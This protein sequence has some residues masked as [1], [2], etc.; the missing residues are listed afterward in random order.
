M[1][2]DCVIVDH[3][4]INGELRSHHIRSQDG[5]RVTTDQLEEIDPDCFIENTYDIG[6]LR[7]YN[8]D[9][10][11]TEVLRSRIKNIDVSSEDIYVQIDH[12]GIPV[13]AGYY[14]CIFP[15]GWRIV[16]ANVYDPYHEK[17][18]VAEKRSYRSVS[19]IWDPDSKHAAIQF[20]M[21]SNRGTFSLGVIAR[22]KQSSTKGQFI[23]KLKPLSIAISDE[24]HKGHPLEKGYQT[25][26][27]E[28]IEQVKEE[29]ER[30]PGVSVGLAGPSIDIVAWGRYI[31]GKVRKPKS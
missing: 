4:M 13:T 19:Y 24:R 6:S 8:A 3:V 23:G 1:W 17:E 9:N 15:K 25:T 31:I 30:F 12:F 16:E 7:I 21:T 18:N 20:E 29:D 22:L 14:A 10:L 11:R 27:D 5:Y 28:V 26:S 2:F